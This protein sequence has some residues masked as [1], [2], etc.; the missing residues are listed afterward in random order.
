MGHANFSQST[1]KEVLFT[2][3]SLDRGFFYSCTILGATF[4]KCR[5]VNERIVLVQSSLTDCRFVMSDFD[6]AFVNLVTCT[7]VTFDRCGFWKSKFFETT[8][9][10]CRLIHSGFNESTFTG[11]VCTS[12][13][14]D[15][16]RFRLANF[17]DVVFEA[18]LVGHCAFEGA[19]LSHSVLIDTLFECNDLGILSE[20]E[21]RFDRVSDEVGSE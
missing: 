6:E 11:V 3:C 21:A 2:G 10:D 12:S 8:F 19:D 14:L 18:S 13:E 17:E 4:E 15:A 20:Y 16:C 1:L 5:A 9:D 7:S